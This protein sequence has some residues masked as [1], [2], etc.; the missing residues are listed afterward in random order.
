MALLS[1]DETTSPNYSNSNSNNEINY[2]KNNNNYNN[3]GNIPENKNNDVKH[4]SNSSSSAELVSSRGTFFDGRKIAVNC[5]LTTV[6]F[7]LP[8]L[9]LPVGKIPVLPNSSSIRNN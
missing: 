8:N 7:Y 3:N 1:L 6:N 2:N 5:H 4:S 9:I